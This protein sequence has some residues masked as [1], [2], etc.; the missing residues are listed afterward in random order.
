M[1]EDVKT[2][3]AERVQ[4]CIAAGIARER[5]CIDPGFGFGKRLAHNLAAAARAGAVRGGSGCRWPSAC[6]ANRWSRH[7]AR[8]A[9]RERLAAS[10]ALATVAVLNGAHIVRAHDVAATL[11]AV[12]IAEAVR[13][14][15]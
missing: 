13:Q 12:R 4:T 14:G 7:W 3:L 8:P 9:S 15:D 10:L 11:D 1:V 2:F 5:L 6:R